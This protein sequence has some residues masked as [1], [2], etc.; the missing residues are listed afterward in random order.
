M[1][2]RVQK[3]RMKQI[4]LIMKN[5][6]VL[7]IAVIEYLAYNNFLVNSNLQSGNIQKTKL[8]TENSKLNEQNNR[9]SNENTS[10]QPK[11]GTFY[12]A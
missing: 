4:N 12:F 3:T 1:I 6:D 10:N 7:K 8:N 9:N 5:M 11:N 2:G